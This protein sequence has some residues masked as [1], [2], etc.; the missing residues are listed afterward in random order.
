M[1][2]N[3]IN[4]IKLSDYLFV[5]FT[6]FLFLFLT[7]YE[8]QVMDDTNTLFNVIVLFTFF[9]VVFFVCRYKSLKTEVLLMALIL[10]IIGL[11]YFSIAPVQM[12]PDENSHFYRAFEI[13]IG[14][15][16]SKKLTD[17]HSSGNI[18]PQ[19]L[20]DFY[21]NHDRLI[22]INWNQSEEVRFSNTALYSPFS[23]IPQSIGIFI[24]R[25]FTSRVFIIYYIGRF[26]NFMTA[27][28]L[29]VFALKKIPFGRKILF[30][31]M[32]MPMTMQEMISLSPDALVNSLSFAFVAFV[33]HCAYRKEK[34]SNKDILMICAMIS[35]IA[36]CK[37]VYI[38]MFL[39]VFLIPSEKCVSKKSAV[40]LKVMVPAVAISLNLIWLSISSRFL[41]VFSHNGSSPNA[42]VKYILLHPMRYV[43]VLVRTFFANSF[44]YLKSCVG[45]S[46]GLLNVSTNPVCWLGFLILLVFESS[47][48][49]YV[50]MPVKKQDVFIFFLV[51]LGGCLLIFTSLYVQWTTL[52][53]KII[54]GVQG[55]YFIPLLPSLLLPIC[56]DNYFR[57]I[58]VKNINPV[59]ISSTY[60]FVLVLFFNFIAIVDVCK[61]YPETW[62]NKSTRMIASTTENEILVK[63]ERLKDISYMKLAVWSEKNGQDDI[64]WYPINNS[65]RE[66]EVSCT[67]PLSDFLDNGKYLLHLWQ[68]A[69][70]NTP[71]EFVTN[72]EINVKISDDFRH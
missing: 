18:L 38:V 52:Q 23:Y 25:I 48:N 62:V 43:T 55:R 40:I 14:K 17:G 22:S 36:L 46:L 24:A 34:I 72:T 60:M 4:H 63:I 7:R 68:F 15:F 41:V 12:I 71:M 65:A 57:R 8:K 31:I 35:I 39:L 10:L 26:F 20:V 30:V 19:A 64:R 45:A 53:A 27:F 16:I 69:D 58:L 11:L 33:L 6:F 70:E 3:P 2:K 54:E 32:L 51:F 56:Y 37:I 5:F 50:H 61:F 66:S 1:I 47:R 42:Q 49:D 13:S 29:S 44:F 67:I 21:Q 59:K 9:I 28:A